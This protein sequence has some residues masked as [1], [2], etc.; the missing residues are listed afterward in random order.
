MHGMDWNCFSARKKQR[1]PSKEGHAADSP[2][3]VRTT[4]EQ[5]LF[6]LL[7]EQHRTSAG[8]PNYR[9]MAAKFNVAFLEQTNL[10]SL[11]TNDIFLLA[12]CLQGFEVPVEERLGLTNA[13]RLQEY[14]LTVDQKCRQLDARYLSET[15]TH[16]V[17]QPACPSVDQTV[18]LVPS[19]SPQC[20]QAMLAAFAGHMTNTNA[21]A[22][23]LPGDPN[24]SRE[25]ARGFNREHSKQGQQL[26]KPL[27]NRISLPWLA[28]T[29][30]TLV[31]QPGRA[32][33]VVAIPLLCAGLANSP[34]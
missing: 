13:D 2:K 33:L 29:M 3:P 4:A 32:I 7:R 14:D 16:S 5:H 17:Q 9:A 27:L 15:L 31:L 18:E 10:V 12:S 6:W 28:D 30:A 23:L 21:A 1:G 22:S 26:Q 24:G 34:E 11:Q 25:S 8:P 19:S 20:P